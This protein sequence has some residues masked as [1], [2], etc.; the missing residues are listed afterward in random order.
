MTFIQRKA[1]D[2]RSYYVDLSTLFMLRMFLST[3]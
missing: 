3:T 1:L 2:K